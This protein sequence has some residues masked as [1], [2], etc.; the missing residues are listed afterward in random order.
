MRPA[1]RLLILAPHPDDEV[2]G[3]GGTLALAAA[4]GARTLVVVVF[5]GAAGDPGR[6]FPREDYV[7][8][9]R[10][11]ARAGGRRLGVGEYR[12]WNR[13][14]GHRAPEHEIDRGAARLARLVEDWRPDLVLAP[15]SGDA[16]G[17]HQS[18]ARA[19]ER[20]LEAGPV[21]CPVWGFEVW[22]PL[23]PDALVDVSG[24][25]RAKQE[26]LA[27]HRTQLAYGDLPG[28]CLRLAG[29]HAP[30]LHEAFCLFGGSP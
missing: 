20:W 3:C 19:V 17:D 24:V 21:P 23:V 26:A 4:R 2:L 5:D 27:E 14:E 7:A 28:H 16:Q 25:W 30:G 8:R 12:F 18:V 22:S 29:G 9:R 1:E 6:K 15:W 13:P 11:E 10:R